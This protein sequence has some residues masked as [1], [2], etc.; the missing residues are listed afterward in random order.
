LEDCLAY[1]LKR[2]ARSKKG[3][4]ELVVPIIAT[5]QLDLLY[6][7]DRADRIGVGRTIRALFGRI[8]QA[9]FSTGTTADG[10]AFLATRDIYLKLMRRYSKSGVLEI[11]NERG[12]GSEGIDN[13]SGL[14]DGVI[15][16]LAAKQLGVMG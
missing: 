9:F 11:L 16:N 2:D 10:R 6:L 7:I 12:R 3:T 5:M 15:V 1:E 8:S 14:T 13:V 4:S